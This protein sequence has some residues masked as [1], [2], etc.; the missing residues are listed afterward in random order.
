VASGALWPA[1]PYRV[2]VDAGGNSSPDV[3]VD[4][5]A[6]LSGSTWRRPL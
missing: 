5:A 2:G 3:A 4:W 1:T 6:L